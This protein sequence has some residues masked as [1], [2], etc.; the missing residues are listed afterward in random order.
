M[1]EHIQEWYN[2]NEDKVRKLMHDIWLHPGSGDL[3]VVPSPMMVIYNALF[4]FFG[5]SYHAAG[6][7]G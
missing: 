2:Q 5:T 4:E 7:H 6:K 3:N 1:N